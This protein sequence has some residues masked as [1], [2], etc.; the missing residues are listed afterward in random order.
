M[1][2]FFARLFTDELRKS[3]Q[4]FESD[5]NIQKFHDSGTEI[6]TAIGFLIQTE[7]P[8]AELKSIKK[9]GHHTKKLQTYNDF[10]FSEKNDGFK[11]L[12]CRLRSLDFLVY[13]LIG[14]SRD[15]PQIKKFKP[16]LLVSLKS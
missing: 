16:H 13:L 2:P 14:V 6:L 9:H 1:E 15:L 3:L 5:G 7:G 4:S 10:V 11:D 8:L 12:R